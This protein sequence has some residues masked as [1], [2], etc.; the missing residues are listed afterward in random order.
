MPRLIEKGVTAPNVAH[1]ILRQ[2]SY[3]VVETKHYDDANLERN[4]KLRNEGFIDKAKFGLH[5]NEDIRMMISIPDGLQWTIF[6]RKFPEVYKLIMSKDEKDRMR[7]CRQLQLLHP[8]WI[9]QER[10]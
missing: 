7:G 9:V 10:L 2:D 5:D 6:K 8:E 3:L 4:K 1:R